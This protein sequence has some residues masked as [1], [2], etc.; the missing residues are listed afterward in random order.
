MALLLNE[1]DIFSEELNP[2]SNSSKTLFS[3]LSKN[4]SNIDNISKINETSS[5]KNEDFPSNYY[6]EINSKNSFNINYEKNYSDLDNKINKELQTD[7]H[8]EIKIA[9]TYLNTI[10]PKCNQD[11]FLISQHISKNLYSNI[12]KKIIKE[13]E[14]QL[15]FF[16]E[17][18]K[19]IKNNILNLNVNNFRIIGYILCLSYNNFKN[20]N[21]ENMQKFKNE[22]NNI[23]K[24]KINIYN[25]YSKFCVER[26]NEQK[27][28]KISK[29]ITKRKNKY[30]LPCELIFLINYYNRINIIDINFEELIFEQNDLLLFIITLMNI[31]TIFPKINFIKLNLINFQ[32]QNDIYC[33]FFRMEKDALKKTNKYIKAFNYSNE[34]N[35]FY[36][37]WDFK[38]DFYVAEKNILARKDNSFNKI[39]FEQNLINEKIHIN[40]LIT[41]YNDILSSIIITFFSLS[42]FINMNKFELIIND[43]YTH[44]IQFFFKKNCLMETPSSF[45]I[46]N[47]IKNQNSLKSINIE[48]NIID[49]NT[50]KK[51][52]YLIHKNN[53]IS[54]L[55]IS[56][57][58]SDVSYLQQTIYKLFFQ[59][60]KN[61][62]ENKFYFIDEPETE[63][64]NKINI[65]FENNLSILF[66]IIV[67]KKNLNKLG[68]Y[69]E[70]PSII[71]NNQKYMI[72]ILKFIINVIFLIDEENS[73]LNVLTL[74]SPYTILDKILFPSIDD[75]LEDLEIYEKNKSLH[76]LNIHLKI[77][78][79]VNIKKLI[80]TNLLIL[81][82]G[83][84]DLVSFEIIIFYLIS[85]KF[86]SKSNL[87][88]LTI[89]LLKS[90]IDYDKKI[91]FLFN[92]LYSIK[93]QQLIELNLY[94][95]IIIDTKE[96]YIDLINIL[97]NHW[98]S[99]SNLVLNNISSNIIKQ[100]KSY[101]NKIKYLV[102]FFIK[103]IIS[104]NK[105]DSINAC[106]WYL[107]S[108]F[109]K[110]YKENKFIKDTIFDIC[111]KII[112]GIFK[113]L[114]CE[115][116]MIITHQLKNDL[117]L[118]S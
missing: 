79:I 20:Y 64:L 105:I 73:K 36:E 35:I 116:K 13:I 11:P 34:E 33:R 111:D 65:Y 23:D 5:Q 63:T 39:D 115:R 69:F 48:L 54:E 60:S 62:K 96:K 10:F 2:G 70:V 18:N 49:Y 78:K 80:S 91:N 88:Y 85:Y 47:F 4:S 19:R 93:I 68:L 32:F 81:N 43:S 100:C 82:I 37:K 102:P 26:K 94:T 25:D 1:F 108:I 74:L 87:K 17:N 71:V 95:N 89:G 42:Q 59:S 6:L 117:N 75:Y 53:L 67:R 41:K 30:L 107:R 106:Y 14:S 21:I 72:T 110:K 28:Y 44:E 46:L 52:F 27:D 51:I 113:Y 31:Q 16:E 66:D 98:I 57:F 22:I 77:Y 50:S 12:K 118:D 3:V 55:Q 92:K 101:K 103:D 24:N 40:E 8:L 29:F 97:N 99:S 15:E 90:I 109:I 76:T 86:S 114:C 56:F 104:N 38:Y 84:F 61:K 9:K 83:D 112:Y 58:T 45:H 7:S